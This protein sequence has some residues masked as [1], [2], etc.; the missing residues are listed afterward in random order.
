MRII[1]YCHHNI[2]ISDDKMTLAQ[3]RDAISEFFPELRCLPVVQ[4]GNRII[5]GTKIYSAHKDSFT[6]LEY[7]ADIKHLLGAPKTSARLG[8]FVSNVA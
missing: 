2:P 4:E 7:T 6:R 5:F 3:I 1:S 8:K